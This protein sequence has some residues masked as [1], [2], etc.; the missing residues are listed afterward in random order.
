MKDLLCLM[1]MLFGT[2]LGITITF[3]CIIGIA[4]P[5]MANI[6][7]IIITIMIICG[8]LYMLIQFIIAFIDC[9]NGK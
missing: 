1:Y 4:I 3:L 9:I 6:L 8:L 5:S 2:P 7:A